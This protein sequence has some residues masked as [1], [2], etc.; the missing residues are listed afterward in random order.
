M[1]DV[2]LTKPFNLTDVPRGLPLFGHLWAF[3]QRPLGMMTEWWQQQGD[4][5]RF[6]LGPTSL[7]LFSHPDLAEEV[8]VQQSDRFVKVYEHGRPTGLALVLGNGLVTSSGEVWKRHRRI[9]QPVFHRHR[10]AAVAD[11]MVQVG[12]Q[13]L[14]DWAA[15]EEQPVDIAVEMMQLA[16]EVISQTMFHTSVA[17]HTDQ[18]SHALRVSLKYAFDSFHNPLQLPLWLPTPRN[19]AFHAAIRFLD[20]LIYGLL[21]ERR[22]SGATHDDLLDL[23]LRARDEETDARLSDRELRDEALTIFA[24]GHETTANALAWTWYLLATHPAAKARFHEEV[25]RVLQGRLPT[26]DDLPSL[27]YTRAVFDESLRLY[28]PVPAVQRK[29]ATATS[30]CGLPLPAGAVVLVCTYNLHRHPA[31]WQAP[32]RFMPERWLDGTRPPVRGAYLPFGAGPRA[33]VGTHFATVEAQLLLALIG[34]RYDPQL[35][36]EHVEPDVMVTLRPKNGI[37]MWLRPRRVGRPG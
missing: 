24:A 26:A 29:A 6:R 17:T 2:G 22:R 21:A 13:R 7:Y 1:H 9:I 18:I 27:A 15:R 5:L 36:Q 16:L 4:A 11:R 30:V 14:A 23:L 19:R 20:Q 32:N 35:A 8:L 33:C 12:E 10:M 37:R 31:F 34:R 25:D 3:K 28:P